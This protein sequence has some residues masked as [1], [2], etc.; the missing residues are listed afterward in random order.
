MLQAISG[1]K[2]YIGTR[3][4]LPTDLTVELSDFTAQ[5]SEWIEING[6]TNAGSLGDTR[7]AITQNFIG[8]GRTLTINGTANSAALD[9]VFSPLP[10]DPGQ[11]R[12]RDAVSGCANYAFKIEWGAG[13]VIEDTV[14]I[15]NADPAVITWAGGH[16]LEAGSPVVF[17][18][19][20]SLPT[21]L[22]AGTAY[23]VLATDLTPTT[24][25]VAATPGGDPIAT[26]SDGTGV[27][28]AVLC[29]SAVGEGCGG[30]IGSAAAAS[31]AVVVALIPAVNGMGSAMAS[32]VLRG[33]PRRAVA[34][35]TSAASVSSSSAAA[36]VSVASGA[37]ERTADSLNGVALSPP[38][39]STKSPVSTT[40]KVTAA[41]TTPARVASSSRP[42]PPRSI[43]E[44][45]PHRQRLR[46]GVLGFLRHGMD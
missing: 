16:G 42:R 2:I 28:T 38:P 36:C 44:K 45:G 8:A 25:K 3:V 19:D 30:F 1:S 24:F 18:T 17:T 5:E 9:N 15:S 32:S 31:G 6:W 29:A 35:S 26:T 34:V 33:S 40:A 23:Y 7:E 22:T 14:T 20:G 4:A 10:N 46:R 43:S 37:P 39:R 41:T 12:L 21:G 27:L 11:I 13:C